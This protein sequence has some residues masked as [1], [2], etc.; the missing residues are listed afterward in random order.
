MQAPLPGESIFRIPTFPGKPEAD[1][2]G[3]PEADL[4]L[5]L[6]LVPALGI[7]LENPG[8]PFR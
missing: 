6:V 8:V 2:L 1:F 4:V 5:V 3:R 7:L